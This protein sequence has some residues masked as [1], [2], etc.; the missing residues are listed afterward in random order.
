MGTDGQWAVGAGHVIPI[1]A[2]CLLLTAYY[3]HLSVA[4][5]RIGVRNLPV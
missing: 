3:K 2:F 1:A 5:D 4:H